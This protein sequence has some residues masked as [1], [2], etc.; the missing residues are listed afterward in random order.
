MVG[1]IVDVDGCAGRRS[2]EWERESGA[3][4]DGCC[5]GHMWCRR[6]GAA[7]GLSRCLRGGHGHVST[8]STTSAKRG[9]ILMRGCLVGKIPPEPDA[10]ASTLEQHHQSGPHIKK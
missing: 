4:S 6:V 2:W 5:G 3:P 9:G 10:E 1:Y 7:A 8:V